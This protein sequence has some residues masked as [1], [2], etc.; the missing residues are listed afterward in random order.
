MPVP[1]QKDIEQALLQRKKQEL[2][3]MYA[4][5]EFDEEQEKKEEEKKKV[6]EKQE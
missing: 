3:Q 6:V 5:D 4:L 2:V 1:S